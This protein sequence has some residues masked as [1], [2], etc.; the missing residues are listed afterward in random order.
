MGR[1]PIVAVIMMCIPLVN[2]YLIY[3]W[4]TEIKTVTKREDINPI[5]QVVFQIIPIVNIWAIWNLFSTVEKEAKARKQPGFPMGATVLLI[6]GFLTSFV[7][8]GIFVIL[9]MVYKAQD[10]LNAMGA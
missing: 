6:V 1:S 9:F 7:F 10:M 5:L 2:L 4:W 8:I 3:K